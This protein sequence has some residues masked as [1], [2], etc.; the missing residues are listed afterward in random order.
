MGRQSF[1][2]TSPHRGAKFSRPRQQNSRAGRIPMAQVNAV[3]FRRGS[4]GLFCVFLFEEG[5]EDLGG[6]DGVESF[7]LFLS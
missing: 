1:F 3:F 2:L 4:G 6:G 5:L 7:F